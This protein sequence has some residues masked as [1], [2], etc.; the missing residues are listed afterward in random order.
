MDV[1]RDEKKNNNNDNNS[2]TVLCDVKTA[3]AT[4]VS[5]RIHKQEFRDFYGTYVTTNDIDITKR[6]FC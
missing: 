2:D 4:I 1:E 5:P 3:S 6:E